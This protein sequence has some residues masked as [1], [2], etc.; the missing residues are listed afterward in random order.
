MHSAS[1]AQVIYFNDFDQYTY[2]KTYKETDL[3]NDWNTAWSSGVKERRV[4]IEKGWQAYGNNGSCLAIKYPGNK[5]GTRGTGA[6]WQHELGGSYDDV[7]LSYSVKFKRGFDFV[8]GGKLPGLAGGTAPTGTTAATGTNGFTSRM[9]W[10]TSHTGNPGSPKQ[11]TTNAISY[12]KYFRSGYDL[13]GKDEDET[14]FSTSGSLTELKSNVWYDI[15]QRVKMNDPWTNNGI[16]Q[17]WVD[18]VLV[19]NKQNVRFRTNGSFGIDKVY[20]STFFGGGWSWRTSKWETAYFDNFI[21][22]ALD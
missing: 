1:D 10:L 6:Q 4:K 19:V 15:T 17:I 14:Y 20:F 21:V 13:D 8:K 18:D 16:I 9:M 7:M 22:T 11:K 12:A 2:K 5:Y 3:D